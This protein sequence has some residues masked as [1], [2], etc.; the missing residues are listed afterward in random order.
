MGDGASWITTGTPVNPVPLVGVNTLVDPAN[1]FAAKSEGILLSHDDV[2]P[3]SGDIRATMN[4]A[5]AGN[6]ANL[7]NQSDWSGRAELGLAG[8]EDFRLRV[9]PDGSQWR[10]ALVLDRQTGRVAMPQGRADMRVFSGQVNDNERYYVGQD[11]VALSAIT[12]THGGFNAA[13]SAYTVPETGTYM[14]GCSSITRSHQGS[15]YYKL[16][17]LRNG[18]ALY[19]AEAINTQLDLTKVTSFDFVSL[20]KGETVYLL[21][22]VDGVATT[23]Q[24]WNAGLFLVR[25]V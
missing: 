3:E 23:T 14:I 21:Y 12:D 1:R 17:P 5:G 13:A 8:D 20:T 22:H 24:F 15:S 9:S 6:T 10:D 4:K 7:I 16:L 11:L 25:I 2:T 18:A 19:G